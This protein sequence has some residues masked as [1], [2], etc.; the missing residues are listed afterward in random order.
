MKLRS[1]LLAIFLIVVVDVLGLT[2]M[3]PLLP[4]YAESFNASPTVVGL[5]I[6]SY[7]LCQLI[8]GPVLGQ[9]SD[10]IGRKPVLTASQIGTF[11]GFLVLAWAPNLL[12]VFLAR[13]VDGL[14]KLDRLEFRRKT[15]D[16]ADLLADR[17]GDHH[18]GSRCSYIQA[19]GEACFGVNV[20]KCGLAAGANGWAPAA[21]CHAPQTAI[22][23]DAR[24]ASLFMTGPSFP[25]WRFV[26]DYRGTATRRR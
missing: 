8:A 25:G 13:I 19:D 18:K 22:N 5:L 2:I 10:R 23:S 12:V 7:A 26:A 3:L 20:K 9:I 1:P 11:A 4:F 15:D 16:L 17:V 14:T 24:Y 6:S 21:P